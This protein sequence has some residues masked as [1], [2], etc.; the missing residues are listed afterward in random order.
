[1]TTQIKPQT[2]AFMKGFHAIIRPQWMS[3]FSAQEFQRVISGDDSDIDVDE[4]R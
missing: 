2:T 3:I 1:M 4:L